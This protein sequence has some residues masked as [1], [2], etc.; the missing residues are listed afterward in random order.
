[1]IQYKK[2]IE[3]IVIF[4]KIFFLSIK[5]QGVIFIAFSALVKIKFL[6]INFKN[7]LTNKEK[8]D[9]LYTYQEREVTK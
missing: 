6:K 7:L 5:I 9:I 3:K 2:V 4:D 8:C 1:M